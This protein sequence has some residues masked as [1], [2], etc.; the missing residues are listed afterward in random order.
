MVEGGR[1][2]DKNRELEISL[3]KREYPPGN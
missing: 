2:V 1:A 3:T